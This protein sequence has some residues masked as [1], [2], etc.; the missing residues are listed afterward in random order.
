MTTVHTELTIASLASPADAA[1]FRTI[2]EEWICRLFTLTDEDR[3]ILSDPEA[4]I[5][6][7]GG[8]VLFARFGDGEAVGCVALLSHGDGVFELSKMG[9]T[10]E[11][12]GSGIGRRL[13]EAAM[14]RVRELGG[15]RLFLGSNSRLKP[16]LHLYEEAGF[17]HISR[18]QVPV[19]DYY[20]RADVLMERPLA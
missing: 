7:R 17:R 19:A 8:D 16:A 15:R 3:R 18:D 13:I 20:A 4:Q 1:A 2:N 10:P 12:Q 11:A 14:A 5:L 6:A 9:V